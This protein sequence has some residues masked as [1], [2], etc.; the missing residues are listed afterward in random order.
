MKQYSWAVNIMKLNRAIAE[1]KT[2][3]DS[4]VKSIYL[5]I[6]GLMNKEYMPT[7]MITPEMRE[8]GVDETVSLAKREQLVA[9]LGEEKVV[10]IEEG[11]MSSAPKKRGRP[12]KIN[13]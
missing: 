4:D 3:E 9:E 2:K 5:R 13:A 1:S 6:G 11:V 7:E 8:A 10:E 12:A